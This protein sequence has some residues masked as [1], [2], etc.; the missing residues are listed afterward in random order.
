MD[1]ITTS[2]ILEDLADYAKQDAWTRF[3]ERFRD[4]IER[5][6]RQ[7]GLSHADAEEAA[8]ETL[9]AFAESYR[10]GRY[11]REKGRLSQWLF[12]IAFRQAL[13]T[14]RSVMRRE[15]VTSQAQDSSFW[16]NVP[17]QNSAG[18][19]WEQQWEEAVV[20]L[21]LRRVRQEVE[22]ATMRAFEAVVC[23]GQTA[24]VAARTLGVPVKAVYNAKYTVLKRMRQL[25]TDLEATV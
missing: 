10:G 14:R 3:G 11:D 23:Q 25:R 21:C 2:T 9:L 22:P 20:E 1:W 8:Q 15:K 24:A 6:A 16:R 7:M 18:R 5:F 19:L 12:G 13:A 4:P 17:D